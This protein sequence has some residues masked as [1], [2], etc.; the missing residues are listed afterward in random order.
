MLAVAELKE[1]D[2]EKLWSCDEFEPVLLVE[3][4]FVVL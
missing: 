4:E 2:P 3:E 1:P